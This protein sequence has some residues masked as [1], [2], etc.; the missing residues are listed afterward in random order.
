MGRRIRLNVQ[1][2][3]APEHVA[4]LRLNIAKNLASLAALCLQHFALAAY[5]NL[6][7]LYLLLVTS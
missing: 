4:E 3:L 2:S 6:K 1:L 7:S 5:V